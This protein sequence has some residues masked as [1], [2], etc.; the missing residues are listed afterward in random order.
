MVDI[1]NLSQTANPNDRLTSDW[2]NVVRATVSDLQSQLALAN[3][4]INQ[5]KADTAQAFKVS[6]VSALNLSYSGGSVALTSGLIAVIQ[7]GNLTAPNNATSYIFIND[8]GV[9]QIASAL[10]A[11][12]F[13]I[14]RV[15]TLNNAVTVLQNYPLFA[16][17]PTNI[18]LGQYATIAYA[19]SRKW[20]QIA[21]ARKTALQA[22]TGLASYTTIKFEAL[23]GAG[24]ATSGV[25]THTGSARKY[26]F[27]TSIRIDT[28]APNSADLSVKVSLFTNNSVEQAIL[29]QGRS[30]EGDI[31]GTARNVEPLTLND[32]DTV[33][34]K[35]YIT[36]GVNVRVR[37]NYSAVTAWR[38][39][40]GS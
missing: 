13:A 24:F 27:D 36:S 7:P 31:T 1:V 29:F 39:P 16:T 33:A 3:Q 12:G 34:I 40:P 23:Q 17:R 25:F 20:E 32:G 18:D 8:A 26:V 30:A 4:T 15:V 38:L 6:V 35:A 37:E 28:T 9:V 21:T 11:I 14:A 22:L 5:L 2:I 19:D 10:P